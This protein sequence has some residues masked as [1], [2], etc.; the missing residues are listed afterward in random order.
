[1]V[2]LVGQ[3]RLDGRDQR[4]GSQ[5]VPGDDVNLTSQV[6][7]GPKSLFGRA[8][9]NANDSISALEQLLRQE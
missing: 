8:S 7:G 9:A 6:I 5:Q 2:D 3:N 1:V 4:V